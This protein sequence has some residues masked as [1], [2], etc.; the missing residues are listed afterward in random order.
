MIWFCGL[1]Y[2][3]IGFILTSFIH[4]KDS[5]AWSFSFSACATIFW[6]MIFPAWACGFYDLSLFNLTDDFWRWIHYNLSKEENE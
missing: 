5:W 6:P 3:L 4:Y 2:L 1:L